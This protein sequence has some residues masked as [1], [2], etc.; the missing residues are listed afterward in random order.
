MENK[1]GSRSVQY[2]IGAFKMLMRTFIFLFCSL[3]FA[4]GPKHVLSQDAEIVIEEDLT[5]SIKQLFR[6]V[7]N[8]RAMILFTGTTCEDNP[9]DFV[10]K[11][12]GQGE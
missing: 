6:L 12:G 9:K 11:G 10:E 2:R 8:K 7:N 4:L 3:A 5:L 1:F